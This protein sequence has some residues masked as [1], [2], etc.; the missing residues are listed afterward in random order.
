MSPVILIPAY[1]PERSL[2]SILNT[3]N[4][5][6]NIVLVDD[7]S[8]IEYNTIFKAAEKIPKVTVLHHRKNVGKGQALKTGF[9]YFLE[10]HISNSSVIT[11]DA[12]GQHALQDV[13]RLIEQAIRFPK[14]LWLGVRKFD[15]APWKSRLGNWLTCVAYRTLYGEVLCDTQTG[16]RAIPSSF[17]PHLLKLRANGYDFEL[18]MLLLARR[19]RLPINT[20]PIQT[21]YTNQNKQSHFHP[22]S[23]SL[24]V[25]SVFLR[26]FFHSK[27]Q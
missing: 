26:D 23:D 18:E 24:K 12:D 2:L 9:T 7:G 4:Q 13:R 17:L 15:N 19:Y 16:L 22:I 11:V 8:G 20:I 21:I 25:Y 14:A 10:V 3:L 5:Y 6:C 1:K 27:E